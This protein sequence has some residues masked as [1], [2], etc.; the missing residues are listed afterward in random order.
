M[1]RKRPGVRAAETF[2]ELQT[3][4]N[5]LMDGAYDLEGRT[6]AQVLLRWWM[7]RKDTKNI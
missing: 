5:A 7:R 2:F 4:I 3:V 6:P 1:P